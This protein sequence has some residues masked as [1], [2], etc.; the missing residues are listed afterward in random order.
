MASVGARESRGPGGRR[1]WATADLLPEREHG[2]R[3]E[4]PRRDHPAR[5]A[6]ARRRAISSDHV[7]GEGGYLAQKNYLL[8]S[9]G[10]ATLALEAWLVV[11]AG[12][13]W[14]KAKGVLEQQLPPL[15]KSRA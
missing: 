10:L 15:E 3:T 9:I 13:A 1:V 5:R 14:P 4:R 12:L 11:E 8:T 6:W 7:F 2:N